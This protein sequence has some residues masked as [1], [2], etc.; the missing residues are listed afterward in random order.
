MSFEIYGITQ[1]PYTKDYIVALQNK[2]KYYCMGCNKMYTNIY[3]KWCKPCQIKDIKENF[4]NWTSG[5]G[6]LI[7]LF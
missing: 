3:L 2:Y 5:N 4:I 7:I 1:N 6:K